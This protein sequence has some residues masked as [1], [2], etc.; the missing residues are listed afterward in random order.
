MNQFPNPD[1]PG[2]TV[3]SR[4]NSSYI[5]EW[6]LRPGW[7]AALFL[8]P[9]VAV[10]IWLSREVILVAHVSFLADTV[11]LTEIKQAIGSDP[12]NA[13]LIHRLGVGLYLEVQ[14]TPTRRRRWSIFAR[15]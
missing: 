5:W 10:S 9:I 2:K 13:D 6:S 15:L 8:I 7:R 11:A 4:R 3:S 1:P 14:P 12:D